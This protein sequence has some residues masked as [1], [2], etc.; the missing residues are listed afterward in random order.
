MYTVIV[1]MLEA[2]IPL[3]AIADQLD[4]PIRQIRAIEADLYG[5]I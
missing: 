1:E 5:F 3:Q 4:L 2:N